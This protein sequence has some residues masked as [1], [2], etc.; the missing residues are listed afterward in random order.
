MD[1]VTMEMQTLSIACTQ[2]RFQE[3]PSKDGI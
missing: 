3:N 1:Y 2:N